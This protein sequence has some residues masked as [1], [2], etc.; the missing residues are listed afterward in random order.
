[1]KVAVSHGAPTGSSINTLDAEWRHEMRVG[2]MVS[3][4]ITEGRTQGAQMPNILIGTA[5]ILGNNA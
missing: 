3:K 2:R 4:V 5:K 1:L